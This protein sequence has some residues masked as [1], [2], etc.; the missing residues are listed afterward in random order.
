MWAF[1]T[2]EERPVV[3]GFLL[4]MP[5]CGTTWLAGVLSQN[6]SIDFS[7]P[8][9]P[10]ILASHRGTFGRDT[11]NPDL[12]EYGRVFSGSGFRV[13]GSV[14]AFSCP[15]TPNRVLQINPQAR[16]VVCL[17]D[18]V[19]RAFSHWK[20]VR[21]NMA[22]RRHG[23]DWSDFETAWGDQRLKDDSL[24]SASMARWLER[25]GI[26]R[27]LI[28]DSSRMRVSPDVILGEINSHFGLGEFEYDYLSE[29]N[30]NASLGRRGAT[31]LG[32]GFKAAVRIIPKTVRDVLA[33][34]LQKRLLNIYDLPLISRKGEK[35]PLTKSHYQICEGEVVPDLFEFERITGFSTKK[36]LS[37]FH[38]D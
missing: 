4:G 5:K 18:P 16:F 10:N 19:E 20:M 25:F 11:T 30:A 9:E 12:D 17:R 32:R 3:D 31:P 35:S 38:H 21:D 28:V 22:D 36:W 8:K 27:F 7:D 33:R 13:D 2:V 29:K 37:N 23:A 14:H 15:L 1:V 6:P 26:E 34:P 24:W